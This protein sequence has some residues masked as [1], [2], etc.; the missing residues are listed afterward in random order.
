MESITTNENCPVSDEPIINATDED[1]LMKLFD[2]LSSLVLPMSD[3]LTPD[4][5][6]VISE[7]FYKEEAPHTK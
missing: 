5:T 6:I 1:V 7:A 2:Q 3:L 4:T